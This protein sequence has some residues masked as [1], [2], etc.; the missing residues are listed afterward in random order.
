MAAAIRA[1]ITHDAPK[2]AGRATGKVISPPSPVMNPVVEF[3]V[4][5]QLISDSIRSSLSGELVSIMYSC[6]RSSAEDNGGTP[7]TARSVNQFTSRSALVSE[8]PLLTV[9]SQAAK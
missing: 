4:V 7:L 1:W 8:L 2:P 5:S 9:P 3:F 6:A